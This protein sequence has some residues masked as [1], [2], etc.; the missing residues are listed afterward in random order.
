MDARAIPPAALRDADAIE[1]ARVWIAERGLHCS[2]KLGLYA[3]EGVARETLAWG[4]ILAD[5]AGQV[6]DA[7]SADGMGARAGLLEAY[8][9]N[10]VRPPG[11]PAP[12]AAGTTVTTAWSASHV[13]A[14]KAC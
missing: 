13:A 1:L 5:L 3:D 12:P 6:A 2:L 11:T 10:I 7:L 8:V 9:Q 14:T 4:I